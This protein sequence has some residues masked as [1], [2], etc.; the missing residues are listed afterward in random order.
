MTI[1][2]ENLDELSAWEVPGREPHLPLPPGPHHAHHLGVGRVH[3]AE[4]R[5]V[6]PPVLEVLQV[7]QV[8]VEAGDQVV[9]VG[10]HHAHRL[11][12]K[13]EIFEERY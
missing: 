13:R 11:R 12:G 9:V 4:G 3:Q 8:E 1:Y 6:R 10:S 2:S 5:D 7:D